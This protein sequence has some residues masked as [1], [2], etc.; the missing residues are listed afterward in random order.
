MSDVHLREKMDAPPRLHLPYWHHSLR[1]TWLAIPGGRRKR[2]VL[3]GFRISFGPLANTL[4]LPVAHVR[5]A[6]GSGDIIGSP[7][8]GGQDASRLGHCFFQDRQRGRH[9]CRGM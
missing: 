5:M 2:G 8:L 3:C 4:E 9:A 1:Y 7:I 6:Y